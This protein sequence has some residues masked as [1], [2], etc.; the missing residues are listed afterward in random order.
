MIRTR[1]FTL[2]EL[3][4]VLVI[5]TV[6][7]GGLAMP[8]SAQIQARRIAETRKDMEAIQD[9]LIG[10]A[11][12]HPLHAKCTCY[13]GNDGTLTIP[14]P[15]AP[16]TP[17]TSQCN[18]L[19]DESLKLP[20]ASWCPAEGPPSDP[21][22]PPDPI[23]LKHYQLPCPADKNNDGHEDLQR[24]SD[25]ECQNPRG[26]LPWITLGVKKADA[27]GNL[28]TY[29]VDRDYS[30]NKKG[31]PSPTPAD[32]ELNMKI[33]SGTPCT[34][35]PSMTNLAVVVVS[36]GPNGRGA[37]NMNGGTPLAASRVP[38]DERQNLDIIP[39]SLPC[40]FETTSFVSRAPYKPADD[41]EGERQK[42][43]DD[44]VVWISDNQLRGRVCPAGGCR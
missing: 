13:Y 40:K 33:W 20:G 30:N 15:T 29:A 39:D 44:L 2:I 43:F 27:W 22:N 3:A 16:D 17:D 23:Y 36:H 32:A 4:I 19:G 9:A 7:I 18:P 31:F 14:P 6:L 12:S 24:K 28:Y 42:E 25:G 37:R 35:S 38:R 34:G 5:I 1:G 8:L 11:M 10:Y 21:Y 41:S 26:G